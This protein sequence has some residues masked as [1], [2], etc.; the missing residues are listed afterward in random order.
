[1]KKIITYS[2]KQLYI[3]SQNVKWRWF[4]FFAI[5]LWSGIVLSLIKAFGLVINGYLLLSLFL[6]AVV[7][8]IVGNYNTNR[9]IKELKR[10][11]E[12]DFNNQFL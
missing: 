3:K 12:E 7:C 9:Y 10:R 4:L 5:F 1:M 8:F 2:E 11:E 6:L